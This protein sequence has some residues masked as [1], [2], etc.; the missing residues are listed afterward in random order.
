MFNLYQIIRYYYLAR[1]Y[2]K[3]AGYLAHLY[4]PKLFGLRR[5][6][7]GCYA[8]MT[9]ARLYESVKKLDEF[10][11]IYDFFTRDIH[12]RIISDAEFVAPVDGIILSVGKL[13]ETNWMV[14]QVKDM[15]KYPVRDIL[16]LNFEEFNDL[17]KLEN[18]NYIS[19][20]LPV[21][22][23]HRFRSPVDWIVRKRIHIPGMMYDLNQKNLF[24][25]KGVLYNERVILEGE[26]KY[27][28]FYFIALGSYKV[29][30]VQI[31]FDQSLR[32]NVI[33]ETWRKEESDEVFK[34]ETNLNGITTV[35]RMKEFKES[36]KLK[37]GEEFGHFAGG[38]AFVI[39]FQ[40]DSVETAVEPPQFILYGNPLIK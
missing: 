24:N 38:S 1:V 9:N 11:N 33:G 18:L 21:S 16:G 2:S 6:I 15:M 40:H 5:I 34:E 27:G 31:Y 14:N 35:A 28:K 13:Q 7:I 25:L 19:I 29:G 4:I 36:V 10:E 37:K 22:E 26:W 3:V 32:T 17:K 23:C 12:P 20:Q 30:S 39:V 8:W